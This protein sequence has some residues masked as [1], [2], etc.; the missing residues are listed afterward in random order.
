MTLTQLRYAVAVDIHRHFGR[1]AA[2]CCVTQPTLSMQLQ[3]LEDELGFP[4]F[5][6]SHQPVVATDLGAHVI[7]QAR[8]VLRE[9][10]R[11]RD[12]VADV[13][14]DMTGTLHLGIIPTLAP[15]VLP[16]VTVPFAEQYPGIE[17]HVR[18]MPTAQIVE[19]LAT[20]RLH[21][22]LIATKET[23]PG[24]ES[25]V[26][27]TEPFYAYVAS[28]HRLA[29]SETIQPQDLVVDDLWLLSEGHCFRDQV[30]NLCGKASQA[31][32]GNPV[33][34]ESG[35]LETLRILVNRTGG[36][37]LLPYLATRY[38]SAEEQAYVRPLSVPVPRRKVRVIYGHAYLKRHL[39]QAYVDT[40]LA[41]VT[42]M[43]EA[44]RG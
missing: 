38:L 3:K 42:P 19:H 33:R 31:G 5:D 25:Q 11:I 23:Q 13:A 1:A 41:E 7:S 21:A 12:L 8:V 44:I 36:M 2:Q 6:R 24:L 43:L 35:N 14:H 34:F 22:G 40:L 18:E 39:I 9:Q 27:F 32:C 26:L 15:Y 30:L 28:Q 20:D 17:V 10:E 29:G 4:L 37:T 16:L